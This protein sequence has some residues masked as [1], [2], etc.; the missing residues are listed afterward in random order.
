MRTSI[1]S[2]I[3]SRRRSSG[4]EDHSS[5]MVFPASRAQPAVAANGH[6]LQSA[7]TGAAEENVSDV[8]QTLSNRPNQ[9]VATPAHRISFLLGK[10]EPL[11]TKYYSRIRCLLGCHKISN[12]CATSPTLADDIR[13]STCEGHQGRWISE[14]ASLPRLA[15]CRTSLRRTFNHY[16][17]LT[18][19]H[20]RFI[21]SPL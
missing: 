8:R 12:L 17:A 5:M 18:T 3:Q 21:F 14:N 1:A 11:Q 2:T 13:I 20:P 10:W 15:K 4:S 19:V 16:I 7:P 9:T 6:K